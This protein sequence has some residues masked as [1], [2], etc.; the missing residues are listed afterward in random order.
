MITPP[1]GIVMSCVRVSSGKATKPK[2]GKR[3][4]KANA[5]PADHHHEPFCI[6]PT[7]PDGT[8]LCHSAPMAVAGVV[9]SWVTET[10]AGPQAFFDARDSGLFLTAPGILEV[11]S[12]LTHLHRLVVR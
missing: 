4:T 8:E 6:D 7:H 5:D 9:A 3:R 1:V 2:S 11:I 10:A 12:Q